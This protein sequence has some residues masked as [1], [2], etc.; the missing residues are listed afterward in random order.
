MKFESLEMIGL[1]IA[2]S[3]LQNNCIQVPINIKE[4]HSAAA[5]WKDGLIKEY[6]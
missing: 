5:G 1:F 4:R 6:R 2:S 3:S